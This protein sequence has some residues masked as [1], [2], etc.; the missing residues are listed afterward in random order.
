MTQ[1]F[2]DHP[3]QV[4]ESKKGKC[5]PQMKNSSIESADIYSAPPTCQ[6]QS[7]SEQVRQGSC[8]HKSFQGAE[9]KGTLGEMKRGEDRDVRAAMPTGRLQEGTEGSGLREARV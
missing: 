1:A 2:C 9:K 3:P 8:H 5:V 7:R 6:A 4:A